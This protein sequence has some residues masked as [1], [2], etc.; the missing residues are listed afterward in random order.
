MLLTPTQI[1]NISAFGKLGIFAVLK[2]SPED[3]ILGL[4]PFWPPPRELQFLSVCSPCYLEGEVGELPESQA[5][6]AARGFLGTVRAGLL[7]FISALLFYCP[8]APQQRVY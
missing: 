3:C 6:A 7:S 8:V 4:G 2:S 5:E 1:V